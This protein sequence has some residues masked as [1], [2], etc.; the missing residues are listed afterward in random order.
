MVSIYIKIDEV[1]K[2]IEQ[3]DDEKISVTSSIQNFNDIAKLFTDYSQSFTVPSSAVNN[4][5]FSHWYSSE[6][7]NGFDHRTR[8]DAYIEIDTLFFKAGKL[9]IEKA[10]KKDGYIENYQVTFYGNLTQL[11]DKFKDDKLQLAFNS[12][13]ADT[14]NHSYNATEVI[15]RISSSTNY[16][17][18]YPLV[19][20]NRKLTYKD[21]TATDITTNAGAINW[22][23]LFP[24]VRIK[25]ILD[26]ISQ[27]YGLTF[28]G[29]FLSSNQITNLWM[30]LKNSELPRAYG[31]GQIVD[32]L[33]T[34]G[35]AFP[36]M[37]LSTN[38][39]T[40]QWVNGF[41]TG[42]KR[43]II[44]L[45][46]TPS[47]ANI[48]KIEVFADGLIYNTYENLSGTQTVNVYSQTQNEDPISHQFY[49]KVSSVGGFNFTSRLEYG[50]YSFLLFGP[51]NVVSFAN[52]N[53]GQTLSFIQ[54]CQA[55]VPEIK[56]S[57]FFMGL[58][59][60]FNLIVTPI[61]ETT[62]DLQPLDLYYQ[63]GAVKEVSKYIDA[64]DLDIEK[65]KLFKS[66]NFLFEKSENVLNEYFRGAFNRDYGDLVFENPNS[67]E[68]STYEVKLPFEN[69]MWEK[70]T[71]YNFI[72]NTF[73]DKALSPYTPKPVL[74]YDNGNMSVTGAGNQIK[75]YNGATYPTISSYRRFTNEIATAGTDLGYL[76]SLNFGLEVSPWYLVNSSNGLYKRF[77]E[78]YVSNLYNLQTRVLKVKAKVT[79]FFLNALKLKDRLVI[80]DNRYII[81]TMTTDLTTN[82]VNFELINDFRGL[83]FNQTGYNF[84]S[85]EMLNVDNT[86]QTIPIIFYVGTFNQIFIPE[87]TGFVTS[88]ETDI[89]KNDISVDF[90]ISQNTTGFERTHTIVAK[91]YDYDGVSKDYEISIT[92]GANIVTADNVTIKVDTNLITTDNG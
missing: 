30:L 47:N 84:A 56:T 3:F 29:S 4:G 19:G 42:T 77:Y 40:T 22:N 28:T 11:K 62:F 67:S 37:N 69:P 31:G 38:I 44:S 1:Y 32:F 48:Y 18:R 23:D 64:D 20:N 34:S 75:I 80:R 76:Y 53:T 79:S 43:I 10:N 63:S 5:I 46:I 2:R 13:I 54:N 21:A 66:I 70:T 50:R 6:V 25:K 89:V 36:E 60:M 35:D 61:N 24:A 52:N 58:V 88:T 82:E 57:D 71:D 7:A 74:M 16:D 26:I 90:I 81:N 33:T 45:R 14:L 17:V 73:L 85:V 91:F 51:Y 86:A 59:K 55:Y 72:T 68:S 8:Y 83:F 65:P 41:A 87:N 78:N 39:V 27:Y 9:Q 92:Q 15:N 49:Y 12:D